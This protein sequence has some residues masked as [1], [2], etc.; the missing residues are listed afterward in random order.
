MTKLTCDKCDK[1]YVNKIWSFYCTICDYD[2]CLKCAKR[3]ISDEEFVYNSGIIIE[4]HNH[5][6]VYMFSNMNWTC[7]LCQEQYYSF[8][9][10]YCCTNCDYNICRICKENVSDVEKYPFFDEGHR[11]DFEITKINQDCHEHPLLY[12]LT[13]RTN[14]ATNWNCNVCNKHFEWMTGLF[15]AL[16]VIMIYA[17]IVMKNL[18]NIVE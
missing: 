17:M 3:Y 8:A 14:I 18:K 2:L 4:N 16:V 15:I 12:C 7:Y 11:K 9:P 1:T 10:T 5:P 13:S 6:L